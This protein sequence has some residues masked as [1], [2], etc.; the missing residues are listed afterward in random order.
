MSAQ[1]DRTPRVPVSWGSP[2]FHTRDVGPFEF[3]AAYFPP[4][5]VLDCHEHDRTVVAITLAGTIESRIG[6]RSLLGRRDDVWTEPAGDRHSNRVG[7]EGAHVLVIQPDPTRQ[8]LLRPCL[9]LLDGVHQFRCGEM[10]H[11]ARCALPELR[12]GE[13]LDEL[14]LE[15]LALQIFSTGTRRVSRSGHEAVPLERALEIVH[16]RF[17][18]KLT[19]REVAAAAGLHPAYLARAFKKRTGVTVGHYIRRLRLDWAAR[20]LRTTEEPIGLIALRARFAD[21]SHFTRAFRLYTGVTPGKYR[22]ARH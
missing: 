22:D 11:L 19:V 10:A 18:E 5:A 9:T 6:S 14:M 4:E 3:T 8:D 1:T 16:D 13:E 21:Q 15:G 12:H 7:P 17:R 2:R 20:Q